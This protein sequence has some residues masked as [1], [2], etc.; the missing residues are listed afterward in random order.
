MSVS[1]VNRLRLSGM[2]S[3]L[4]TDAMVEKLMSAAG[5]KLDKIK[6]SRQQVEWRKTSYLDF[7]NQLRKFRE[8]YMSALNPSKN[9][10]S[11][12]SYTTGKVDIAGADKYASYASIK[13]LSTAS[14]GSYTLEVEK[15]ATAAGY[16][17]ADSISKDGKGISLTSKLDS[18]FGAGTLKES[19]YAGTES[20]QVY[21]AESQSMKTE[22]YSIVEFNIN[23][24]DFK[25]KAGATMRNIIDTVNSSDAG[26]KMSYSELS[27]RF[28][29]TSTTSGEKKSNGGTN[30]VLLR[31]VSGN[32]L[33]AIGIADGSS[34]ESAS[35]VSKVGAP[36][37]TGAS[38]TN[39]SGF[40]QLDNKLTLGTIKQTK[41]D[42]NGD[43]VLDGDG[44]PIL[45]TA[46]GLSFDI[47]GQTFSFNDTASLDDIMTEVNAS[48]KAI[49]SFSGDR[50]SIENVPGVT[51]KITLGD[52]SGNFFSAF[53]VSSKSKSGTDAYG[54][55]VQSNYT[56]GSDSQ[57]SINGISGTRSSN[58]FSVDGIS[59]NLSK[60]TAPGENISFSVSRDV[61]ESVTKI[62]EF[63]TELN[64]LIKNFYTAYT[65]KKEYKFTPLTDAQKEAMSEKEIEL[66]ETKAKAGLMKRDPYLTKF[67]EEIRS[68]VTSLV[69]DEN[70]GASLASI[71]FTVGYAYGEAPKITVDQN[72][73]KSSLTENPDKV[74][75]MLTATSSSA[76]SSTKMRES[77]LFSRI[78]QSML[79]FTVDVSTGRT[80]SSGVMISENTPLKA[81]ENTLSSY[82]KRITQ[83]QDKLD[84]LR[85]RYYKQFSAMETALSKLNDQSS[86]LAGLLNNGN[87]SK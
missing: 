56:L 72:K 42:G 37:S 6:Q 40:N 49:M 29:I 67:V 34:F 68:A 41:L 86:S 57:F 25:F 85:E 33:E 32:F 64:T 71:G 46:R 15:L 22:T 10:L 59:Y 84:K 4:D 83:E 81:I 70:S 63:V 61:D 51:S 75:S 30:N 3:G 78:S 12:S 80:T 66:W 58:S 54:N 47:N 53:N 43:P 74:L 5:A 39:L 38:L 31:D 60:V 20:K 19:L 48:G 77:G 52:V 45:E 17:S 73:L 79:N 69:G 44:N 24:K 8:T 65:E 1:S 62:N 23:G 11:A 16:T 7:N 14:T 82:D 50:L 18:L 28:S 13:A 36:I 27:D 76:V 26:V 87:N 55:A 9:M 21:D 2:N 35:D